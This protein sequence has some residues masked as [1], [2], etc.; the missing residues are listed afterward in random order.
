[1]LKKTVLT[2]LVLLGLGAAAF[3]QEEEHEEAGHAEQH[4]TDYSFTFEGPFG[5]FNQ[6]QLQ[7][8]LQVYTE[9]CAACHVLQYVAFRQLSDEGGPALE[10]EQM[11][12]FAALWEVED[13]ETGE[14]R[15]ATPTDHF[16]ASTLENA[17][18]LSL[19]AKGRA[20]FHGPAGTGI[21][22]LL[23]GMGGPEYIASMLLGFTGEERE[24]A[25][26]LLYENVAFGGYM[27]MNPVLSEGLVAY[28]DGTEA[29]EEQMALD[30]SAF[31]M[32]AAE[33]KMMARKSAGLTAFLFLAG[34]TVLL[35]FTNKKIWA[36][37]K[38]RHRA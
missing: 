3:A 2:G 1:M 35:Y 22:Q 23:R 38:G 20:G 5:S 30:V 31:L 25:G 13:A 7:R 36:P 17:P 37:H 29:T 6:S 19:M 24:E 12:A 4:V 8:G 18:D 14:L 26:V 32:W 10:E 16:P 15:P 33:P 21:N 28:E 9:V 34:L 27:A 11:R